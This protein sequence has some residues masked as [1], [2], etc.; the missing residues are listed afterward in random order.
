MQRASD[1]GFIQR[2]VEY[3]D[4]VYLSQRTIDKQTKNDIGAYNQM[5]PVIFLAITGSTLFSNNKAYLSHHQFRDI[6]TGEHDIKEMSF[7][8]M[9]LSKFHKHFH[10]L[11]GDIDQW[12]YYFKKAEHIAPEKL[13]EILKQGTFF[14][15]AYKE[16]EKSAYTPEQLL[17][18]ERY[19]LKEEGIET[20]INDAKFE[21]LAAGQKIDM[22]KGREKGAK[23]K[24]IETVKN[25]LALGLSLEQIFKITGLTEGEI[26][27][28]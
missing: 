7:S 28:I 9:E 3:A 24:A 13:N 10:E 16:L 8:F 17:E 2:V 15:E 19:E 25:A 6:V 26:Q 27:Q 22:E 18:Y 14:K 4:R 20:R 1:T 12:A 5:R 11:K 21:G 23:Q